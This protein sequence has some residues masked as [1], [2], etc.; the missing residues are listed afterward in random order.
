ML[1]TTAVETQPDRYVLLDKTLLTIRL[2]GLDVKVY[3]VKLTEGEVESVGKFLTPYTVYTLDEVKTVSSF[4]KKSTKNNNPA[5][6]L[7]T[8]GFGHVYLVNN[9]AVGKKRALKVFPSKKEAEL[10]ALT[11]R[12]FGDKHKCANNLDF[13]DSYKERFETLSLCCLNMQVAYKLADDLLLSAP[14]GTSLSELLGLSISLENTLNILRGLIRCFR[15]LHMDAPQLMHGDLK[16]ENFVLFDNQVVMIDTESL[17]QVHWNN[18][19]QCY[20]YIDGKGRKI[21]KVRLRTEAYSSTREATTSPSEE[22]AFAICL[23]IVQFLSKVAICKFEFTGLSPSLMV[24]PLIPKLHDWVSLALPSIM[25]YKQH[26]L[27]TKYTKEGSLQTLL[28]ELDSI[29]SF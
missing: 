5:P 1:R 29:L 28:L 11:S 19:A 27:D 26:S 20:E 18:V 22:D 8:G 4:I 9:H 23:V 21:D 14:V 13:Y 10:G 16:P 24:S 12:M 2:A 25:S 15:C 6:K 7:G 3:E 17:A